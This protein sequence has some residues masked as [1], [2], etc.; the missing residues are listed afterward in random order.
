MGTILSGI[1]TG[2]NLAISV[3]EF[4]ERRSNRK[5]TIDKYIKMDEIEALVRPKLEQQRGAAGVPEDLREQIR[6]EVIACL[7][8]PVRRHFTY[9]LPGPM[10]SF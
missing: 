8:F 2:I 1:A 5:T 3:K 10:R 6:S 9:I 4:F 7:G